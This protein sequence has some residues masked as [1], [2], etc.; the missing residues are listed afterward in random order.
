MKISVFFSLSNGLLSGLISR[1]R[2]DV[3]MKH[4]HAWRLIQMTHWIEFIKIVENRESR[5]WKS[6][7]LY[8]NTLFYISK[9]TTLKQCE[10]EMSR[11]E[12]KYTIFMQLGVASGNGCFYIKFNFNFSKYAFL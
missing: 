6:G 12:Q 11:G 1:S 8:Q 3:I 9:T 4:K 2:G 5:T 7:Y 10:N